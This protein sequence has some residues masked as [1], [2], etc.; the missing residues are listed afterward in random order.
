[1]QWTHTHPTTEGWY[2]I[3]VDCETL[4]R[5]L[6]KCE[7]SPTGLAWRDECDNW[8]WIMPEHLTTSTARYCF[9]PEPLPD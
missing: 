8:D 4:F 1:M 5:Q 7:E 2:R 9:L 3:D 6:F